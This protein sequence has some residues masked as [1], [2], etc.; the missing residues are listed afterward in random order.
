MRNVEPRFF[1]RG[2]LWGEVEEW[3]DENF[4]VI[5]CYGKIV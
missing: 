2:F 5:P 3:I 1:D 4:P